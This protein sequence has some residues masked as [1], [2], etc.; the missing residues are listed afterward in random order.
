MVAGAPRV[1]AR[2][3]RCGLRAARAS[4]GSDVSLLMQVDASGARCSSAPPRG[5]GAGRLPGRPRGTGSRAMRLISDR[6]VPSAPLEACGD[7]ASTTH[8][9]KSRSVDSVDRCGRLASGSASASASSKSCPGWTSRSSPGSRTGSS[10]EVAPRTSRASSQ[11]SARH[12]QHV[13][14]RLARGAMASAFLSRA[15]AP[16]CIARTEVG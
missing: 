15:D 10:R 12:R 2:S 1:T 14:Q 9:A 16:T 7:A 4:G 6:R 13:V 11:R 8:G 3:G 5:A